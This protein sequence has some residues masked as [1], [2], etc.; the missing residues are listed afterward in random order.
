[1]LNH[2]PVKIPLFLL[3]KNNDRLQCRRTR[4]FIMNSSTFCQIRL[5]NGKWWFFL[6]ALCLHRNYSFFKR[7]VLVQDVQPWL[8]S[9]FLLIFVFD[10]FSIQIDVYH[11]YLVVLS[12]FFTL[13]FARELAVGQ[14]WMQRSDNLTEYLYEKFD[15]LAKE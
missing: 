3:M 2:N 11:F 7:N 8:S 13:N 6:S 12:R 5:S 4:I 9:F 15:W 10:S 14:R 1:M